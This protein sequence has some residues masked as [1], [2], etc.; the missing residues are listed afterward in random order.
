MPGQ[1]RRQLAQG[2]DDLGKLRRLV[3]AVARQHPDPGGRMGRFDDDDG[4]DAVELLF[5]EQR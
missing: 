2:A 3:V 1:L 4:A 5:V